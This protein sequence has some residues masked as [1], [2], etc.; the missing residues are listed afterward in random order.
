MTAKIRAHFSASL[1]AVALAL[2]ACPSPGPGGGGGETREN[3]TY[4]FHVLAGVSMG[5]IGAAFNA[6][7]GDNHERLD[8]LISLGGPIDVAFF[9]GGVERSQLGG[10][11]PL[12]ELE[13]AAEA[14]AKDGGN[15]LDDP[16]ALTHCAGPV[17][18][19]IAYELEQHF[20]HW[21]Y[22][23]NGGDF[24]RD[25]YLNMFHDLTLALGN[26]FYFN[27]DSPV[28]PSPE[29]SRANFTS[30]LCRNP[31]RV[32]GF[33]NREY[34][35]QAKYDAITFCD[36]EE[37]R[38][39][40]CDAGRILVDRCSGLTPEQFC[41][42]RGGKVAVAHKGRS[43]DADVWWASRGT[44]HP[45]IAHD[46][47]A[48]FGLALD[49]NG[50]GRR[51]YHE[52]ILINSRE[53]FEDVGAD[54]CPDEREDGRGGCCPDGAS[55]C[56]AGADPN[57]DNFDLVENPLGTE[58]NRIWD[59]GEPFDDHGLDGVPGTGDFGEADERYTEGPNRERYLAHDFRRRYFRMTPQQRRS[60]DLYV[61]G[62]LRDV[63]N[64]GL[65]GDHLHSA[66][67]ALSPQDSRRYLSFLELP[68]RP[69]ENF[70][71]G[72]D[73]EKVDYAKVGRNVFVRYGR[74]AATPSEVRSGDGGHVGTVP[75]LLA[76]FY[77]FIKWMSHRW[78][79]VLGPSEPS[80][81]KSRR[82]QET[83]FSEALQAPRSFGLALPPGY[84]VFTDRRYPVLVVG[85]G[86]GQSAGDMTDLNLVFD[87]L[88]LEGKI[89]D[90]I[91]VYPSGRCCFIN[92]H[93]GHKDCRDADDDGVEFERANPAR[94]RPAYRMEC[95][96]G[97]FYVNRQGYEV[98]DETRYGDS[99][100]ELMDYVDRHYRVLEPVTVPIPEE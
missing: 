74:E 55:G 88:M 64:F 16:T 82:F 75:E 8:A 11:C 86:Y 58:R 61:D 53:R 10:F 54:G 41:A 15:R 9:L 49:L 43:A 29:I 81:E 94:S 52:P 50:N 18:P 57:G 21:A 4:T 1:V 83:F 33:Y 97:N 84:D 3:R 98:G 35:P 71:G 95:H 48:I 31:V 80:R 56:A 13:K 51:D 22:T 63:F 79:L 70:S 60:I 87:T 93:D 44:Y 39:L 42:E 28:F 38:V 66:A 24:G 34:N 96:R 73:P 91:I 25:S 46:R 12:S 99:L 90:M 30:D 14:D 65:S 62:G 68:P 92:P 23:G 67:R 69:G 72:Y 20:N 36:G 77:T 76:R 40:Y 89:R 59:P 17:P 6:G 45:C 100:F 5:A 2:S 78:D 32:K 26:P 37:D 47:P 7:H 27:E 19:G 85:H